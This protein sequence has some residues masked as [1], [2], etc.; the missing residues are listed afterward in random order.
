MKRVIKSVAV[1]LIVAA[2]LLAVLS[3][4]ADRTEWDEV[5]REASPDGEKVVAAYNYMSDGDRHAPYGTYVFLQSQFLEMTPLDGYII[6]AG[7]CHKVSLNWA[8]DKEL[9]INCASVGEPNIR[10]Q[11]ISAF[12]ISINVI[13]SEHN[14]S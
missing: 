8:S 10:T 9:E 13:T 1:I 7:Y 5:L 6:F 3:I 11:S 2:A 4:V 14:S 12:G